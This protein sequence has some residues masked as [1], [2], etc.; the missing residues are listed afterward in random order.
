MQQEMTKDVLHPKQKKQMP[1][2]VKVALLISIPFCL[3]TAGI[4]FLIYFQSKGII[5]QQMGDRLKDIGRAGTLLYTPQIIDDIKYLNKSFRDASTYQSDRIEEILNGADSIPQT[6]DDETFYSIPEKKA[7]EI[8][9]SEQFQRVVQVLRRI[10]SGTRNNIYAGQEELGSLDIIRKSSSDLPT[11]NYVYLMSQVADTKSDG[12]NSPLPK[13]K[14]LAYLVDAD[15]L[16]VEDDGTGEPYEGNPIGN[17]FY[18][19]TQEMG[20]SFNEPIAIAEK[21]FPEADEWGDVQLSGYTPI[22]DKDRNVISVM[23]IDY[24]VKGEANKLKVLRNICLIAGI[25][26]LFLSLLI[27]AFI[28]GWINRPLAIL[29]KGANEVTN[30]NFDT[31]IKIDSKDE[32]GDLA[33]AFNTMIGEIKD[34]S[35]HLQKL[36]V[37]F[38]KF[39][40]KEFLF[41]IDKKDILDITIGDQVE[42]EMSVMFSNIGFDTIRQ[43]LISPTNRIDFLNSFLQISG[44]IIRQHKGFIDK[45]LG[46]IIM[47]LFPQNQRDALYSSIDIQEKINDLN[48][49]R[50]KK[51]IPLIRSTIGIHFGRLIMGTIGNMN[52][53]DSTVISDAVNVASRL[54]GLAKRFDV[55]IICSEVVISDVNTTEKVIYSRYLGNLQ[56]KGKKK[57]MK[58]HEVFNNDTS[59]QISL[60]SKTKAK[61]EEGIHLF[62]L[63]RNIASATK[64]FTEI[65]KNNPQDSVTKIYLKHCKTLPKKKILT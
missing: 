4:S 21:E 20:D 26:S 12:E 60:K 55:R 56:I 54:E 1:F 42:R 37:A 22:L 19:V 16:P 29:I 47:A 51:Y 43:D 5:L 44:P 63:E 23:G 14:I 64:I 50:K 58:V 53:M 31:Q 38:E 7:N 33:L 3:T 2:A 27:T 25:S 34:F 52:R 61:F 65:L 11:I 41:E 18:P 45:F 36:N 28:R 59:Q 10:R 13:N 17:I 30:R 46:F 32:M 9:E 57:K 6:D 24:N 35:Q 15:Y 8:M 40:P 62:H 49:E 39:V 48:I